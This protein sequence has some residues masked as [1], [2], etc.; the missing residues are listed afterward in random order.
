MRIMRKVASWSLSDC[1]DNALFGNWEIRA[2]SPVK[3]V[4]FSFLGQCCRIFW[5]TYLG[6]RTSLDFL[7]HFWHYFQ[8]QWCQWYVYWFASVFVKDFENDLYF[9]IKNS[10]SKRWD[11]FWLK[12]LEFGAT[13]I[14][15]QKFGCACSAVLQICT[16]L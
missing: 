4:I 3:F 6:S 9:V 15:S 8:S 7:Y 12:I 13:R 2:V 5:C 14:I 1:V 11:F 10:F 16:F